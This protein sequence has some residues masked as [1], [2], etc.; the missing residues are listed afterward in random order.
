MVS[1]FCC[2]RASVHDYAENKILG[3]LLC[4]LISANFFGLNRDFK[5]VLN[6]RLFLYYSLILHELLKCKNVSRF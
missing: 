2:N 4:L 3:R 1:I 5:D 6:L